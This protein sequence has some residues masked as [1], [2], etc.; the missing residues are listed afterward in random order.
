MC[1]NT[2]Y[3]LNVNVTAFGQEV[4]GFYEALSRGRFGSDARVSEV[5]QT[6]Q[7]NFYRLRSEISDH[8]ATFN[9]GSG[10]IPEDRFPAYL[11]TTEIS[12]RLSTLFSSTLEQIRV[13][14]PGIALATVDIEPLRDHTPK[15][16]L[17]YYS[18]KGDLYIHGTDLMLLNN[19]GRPEALSWERQVPLRLIAD[20]LWSTTLYVP[21]EKKGEY[22]VSCNSC[23]S[24]GPNIQLAADTIQKLETPIFKT[25]DLPL[26]IPI[27]VTPDNYRVCLLGQ[28]NV[29]LASG[30]LVSLSWE[31]GIEMTPMGRS[32]LWRADLVPEGPVQYK[33]CIVRP[34]G[35]ITF[36]IGENR[37]MS[38]G[39]DLSYLPTFSLPEGVRVEELSLSAI[40]R[41]DLPHTE[42]DRRA[43]L[44]LACRDASV[45]SSRA[46][47]SAA[48][49]RSSLFTE[50]EIVKVHEP[51]ILTLLDGT[52]IDGE[53]IPTDS[54]VKGKAKD[55]GWVIFQQ[56]ETGCTAGASAFLMMDRGITPDVTTLKTRTATHLEHSIVPDLQAKSLT[57][58][59]TS[60]R[61][62]NT[63]V[64]LQGLID[65]NGPAAVRIRTGPGT[66]HAI[67][68]DE[69]SSAGVR[70]R[71][72][73]HGWD[74]TI[75]KAAFLKVWTPIITY[76]IETPTFN[77]FI[78]QVDRSKL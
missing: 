78:I 57:P 5:F 75:T 31:R 37:T 2:E 21:P 28:G 10:V 67:V 3:D 65:A 68:V 42:L 17:F 55:G 27:R 25:T 71:D 19:L 26:C 48:T 35:Q 76:I 44:N 34:D 59:K 4:G 13:H 38:P 73:W 49:T 20:N 56:G 60:L 58:I 18:G 66:A 61:T 32:S 33:I 1:T 23:W 47:T 15:T 40:Q 8:L 22:K 36:E 24:V 29:R 54:I 43:A 72:P 46:V 14:N 45:G 51:V 16:V 52:P 70:L 74:I 53:A 63:L 12:S 77:D 7:T 9:D 39:D 11:Q 30:E 6:I 41:E 64:Q 69:I 50:E 62:H